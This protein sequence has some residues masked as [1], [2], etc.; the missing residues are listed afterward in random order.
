MRFYISAWPVDR[1]FQEKI[2]IY[3][4]GYVKSVSVGRVMSELC[5]AGY[6][7]I[8]AHSDEWSDGKRIVMHFAKDRNNL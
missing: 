3:Q 2:G 5:K 4:T 6:S 7:K 8:N 1:K